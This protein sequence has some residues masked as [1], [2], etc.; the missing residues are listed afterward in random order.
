[1]CKFEGIK[2]MLQNP[3]L[4]GRMSRWSLMMSG[5]DIRLVHPTRLKSQALTD[6]LTT[7]SKGNDDDLT[8]E[9]GGEIPSVNTCEERNASW[10]TLQ[11][12]WNLAAFT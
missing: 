9:L 5:Y 12:K 2:C 4:T 10:W 11:E 7:C 3:S 8:E 6:M 1:M